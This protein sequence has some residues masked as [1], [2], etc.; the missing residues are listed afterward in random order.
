M[1]QRPVASNRTFLGAGISGFLATF[2]I[3]VVSEVAFA[4]RLEQLI[5]TRQCREQEAMLARLDYNIK[6]KR[7]QQAWIKMEER[8]WV[9]YS[10]T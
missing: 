5:Y 3:C 2:L 6:E 10:A 7:L 8:T 1:T 4:D 9:K